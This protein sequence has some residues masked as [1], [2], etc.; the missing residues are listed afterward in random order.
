L[1][2]DLRAQGIATI[3]LRHMSVPIGPIRD[4]RALREI[5]SA[6]IELRPDLAAAH[7]SKAGVLARL[8]ARPL[9]IPVVFTAHGWAFTP[10]VPAFQAAVYRRIER[11]FGHL[12]SKIITVSEFDRRLAVEARIAGENRLVTVHNGVAD[13]T[14]PASIP[15]RTT[16]LWC[17][18]W[19][20]FR[21]TPGSLS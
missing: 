7:M 2:D 3:I 20:G 4:L 16:P 14:P 18:R 11:S 9:G 15:K 12:A 10:G 1:V 6:L 13:V 8:A 21:T 17:V 19:R 5:R